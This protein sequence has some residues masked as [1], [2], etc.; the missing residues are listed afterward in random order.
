[1]N[2][3]NTNEQTL[4]DIR[5]ANLSYLILAQNL[6]RSDRDQALFRLGVSEATADILAALSLSQ[7]MRIAN[8]GT[9]LCCIRSGDEMVW[10]L[11]TNQGKAASTAEGMSR[12]HASIVMASRHQEAA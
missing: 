4:S 11:L 3:S 8:T 12:M 1:M 9:L 5:E 2:T 7:M 10:S 6:I